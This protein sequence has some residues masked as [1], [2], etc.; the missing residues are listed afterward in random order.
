[1]EN[2]TRKTCSVLHKR[3]RHLITMIKQK[4]ERNQLSE[5]ILLYRAS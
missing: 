4:F 3:Y 2:A 1:M 5:W